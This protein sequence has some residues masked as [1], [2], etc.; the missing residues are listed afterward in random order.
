MRTILFLIV[1]A[2]GCLW[3][4]GYEPTPEPEQLAPAAVIQPEAEPRR[5]VATG[6]RWMG[7]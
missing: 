5:H 7:N 4:S 1:A 2:G 6:K 3:W